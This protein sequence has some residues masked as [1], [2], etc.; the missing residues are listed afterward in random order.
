MTVYPET[1]NVPGIS[2]CLFRLYN[3]RPVDATSRYGNLVCDIFNFLFI[4]TEKEDGGEI[5]RIIEGK[6]K[7][8]V[9]ETARKRLYQVHMILQNT[10]A[11]LSSRM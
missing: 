3:Y 4:V 11:T 1:S 9:G 10:A 5:R 7:L 6:T 2:V 8:A